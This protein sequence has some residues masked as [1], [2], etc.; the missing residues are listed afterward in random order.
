M[1]AAAGY[2]CGRRPQGRLASGDH[3]ALS[4][5]LV[6]VKKPLPHGMLL[7]RR[8]TR[9]ERQRTSAGL[10]YPAEIKHQL[11][12]RLTAAPAPPHLS[13]RSGVKGACWVQGSSIRRSSGRLPADSSAT[14]GS[15]GTAMGAGGSIWAQAARAT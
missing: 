8:R 15:G 6:A 12:E 2:R 1:A 11:L 14:L 5:Q 9:L 4:A 10:W 3:A 7:I 13:S